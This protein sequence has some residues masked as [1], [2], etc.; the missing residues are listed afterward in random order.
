MRNEAVKR[1]EHLSLILLPEGNTGACKPV[2]APEAQGHAL[3]CS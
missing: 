3:F 2:S 1:G